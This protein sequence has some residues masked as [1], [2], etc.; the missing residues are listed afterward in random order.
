MKIRIL[1]IIVKKEEIEEITNLIKEFKFDA[2]DKLPH[3]EFSIMQKL[4]DEDLLKETFQKFE[5]IKSIELR[6]N[7]RKQQYYSINY[8]LGDGTFVVISIS[9]EKGKPLIING[10]HAKRDYKKFEKY[11][12]KRFRHLF[13]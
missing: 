6:E 3:F 4:T 2:I 11:L 12:R 10:F 13:S 7:E 9:F 5:L 8:E 1:K